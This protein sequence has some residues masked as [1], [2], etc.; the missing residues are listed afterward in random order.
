MEEVRQRNVH[1]LWEI[2]FVKE[3]GKL[4]KKPLQLG[5]LWKG[6]KWIIWEI[7][8]NSQNLILTVQPNQTEIPK[9]RGVSAIWGKFPNNPIFL[10]WELTLVCLKKQLSRSYQ[11]VEA[12]NGVFIWSWELVIQKNM[13]KQIGR[14]II[15]NHMGALACS[16]RYWLSLSLLLYVCT[17][18]SRHKQGEGAYWNSVYPRGGHPGVLLPPQLL[19]Q[20]DDRERA[21]HH[22]GEQLP[23]REALH[24]LPRRLPAA[25]RGHHGMQ[26]RERLF[27]FW[28]ITFDGTN[29]SK[30]ADM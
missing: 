19:L 29:F 24:P 10:F 20:E 11:P 13:I 9:G 8:W 23:R 22:R 25:L 3:F 15:T 27:L 1:K 16:F 17:S 7:F 21:L 18:C 12:W 30:V 26:V 6:K 4:N 5:E 14:V 2:S 28:K